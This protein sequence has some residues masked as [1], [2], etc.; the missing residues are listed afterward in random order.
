MTAVLLNR[1]R[2]LFNVD[3]LDHTE[4]APGSGFQPMAAPWTEVNIPIERPGVDGLG[5]EWVPF[6]FRVS[7]L[8]TDLTLGLTIGGKRLGRLDDV[9]RRRLGRCRGIFPRR[10]ELLLELC[11]RGLERCE[12]PR[13]SF[14]LRLLRV[15]LRLQAR[16]ISTR[17]PCLG[18]HG[19]LC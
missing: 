2:H 14:Q 17:L 10:R 3:L 7:G 11:E 4:L 13:L 6:V 16:T 15:H 18:F 19:S 12:P 5:W 8:A 1:Q 9:R